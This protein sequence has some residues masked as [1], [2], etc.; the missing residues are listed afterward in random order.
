MPPYMSQDL[1]TTLAVKLAWM[2]KLHVH[3][4]GRRAL[5][6]DATLQKYRRFYTDDPFE[7][8]L[9]H[10]ADALDQWLADAYPNAPEQMAWMNALR[11]A[12]ERYESNGSRKRRPLFRGL[13]YTSARSRPPDRPRKCMREIAHCYTS[14]Q[15][16]R[17][18]L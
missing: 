15:V 10:T 2:R 11:G 6:I 17:I 16:G 8:E 18:P 5:A 4:A 1:F 13:W 12:V 14:L 3:D 9:W 7:K